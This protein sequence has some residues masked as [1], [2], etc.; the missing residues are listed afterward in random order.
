LKNLRLSKE[1]TVV[2]D[3]WSNSAYMGTDDFGLPCRS[4][5]VGSDSR[6]HVI[7]NL[8]AA[9]KTLFEKILADAKPVLD[10]C[11]EGKVIMVIPFP[12][13]VKNKCCASAGH[14]PNFGTENY[15][16]E[17]NRAMEV[18]EQALAAGSATA[19]ASTLSIHGVFCTADLDLSE[20]RTSGGESIWG[21]D[22]VHL[23]REAYLDL[24]EAIGAGGGAG[25]GGPRKRA[26]LESVVPAYPAAV[27]GRQGRIR[28][29]SWVS[30]RALIVARGSGRGRGSWG[31]PRGPRAAYWR[32]RGRGGYRARGRGY[33]GGRY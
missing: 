26:R 13:Y 11:W 4:T 12:R 24:A 5:R 22:P 32:P 2:I 28:P 6:Y 30:G 14:I 21:D 10:A 18:A 29:P 16:M 1:D 3:L 27:R 20:V 33:Q 23:S 7:G 25:G 31:V 8:Q 19:V 9:P 17:M 15:F